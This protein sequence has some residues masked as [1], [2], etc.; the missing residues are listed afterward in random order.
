MGPLGAVSGRAKR[1]TRLRI[2][3]RVS[4]RGA[5]RGYAVLP[6]LCGGQ[7]VGIPLLRAPGAARR[8]PLA[9]WDLG[10]PS[11]PCASRAVGWPRTLCLWTRPFCGVKPRGTIGDYP[12]WRLPLRGMSLHGSPPGRIPSRRAGLAWL[13]DAT[14]AH[15]MGIVALAARGELVR[16]GEHTRRG[17]RFVAGLAASI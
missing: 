14:P 2:G 16:R 15:C 6:C 7:R 17:R 5:G 4:F 10:C 8:R 3:H 1:R 9:P 13:V 11:P 12:Q